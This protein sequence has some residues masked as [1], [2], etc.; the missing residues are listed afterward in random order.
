LFSK[1]K[2]K[3]KTVTFFNLSVAWSNNISWANGRLQKNLKRKMTS[4]FLAVLGVELRAVP[5]ETHP[6]PFC[7][8]FF[9]DR[10]PPLLQGQPGPWPSYF[11]FLNSW[12]DKYVPLCPVP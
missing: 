5:F 10:F 3:T 11:C 6:R 2:T 8:G 12:D 7:F 9:W 4:E 1:K